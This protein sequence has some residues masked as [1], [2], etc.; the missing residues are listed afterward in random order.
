MQVPPE[1]IFKGVEETPRIDQA[2]SRGIARLERVCDYIIGVRIALEREQG[3]RQAGNPYRMRIDV[4][5]PDRSD[6]IVKRASKASKR[7]PASLENPDTRPAIQGEL[8]P[9]GSR[10]IGRVPTP[11]RKI[12]EEPLPALIRCTFDSA[13]RELEKVVD[14]QRG[15]VK[16]PAQQE[17][18]AV[19]EKIFRDQEYGFLR[20]LDGQQVYFHRNSV[21]HR[22]WERLTPGTIVRYT[23]EEG[24][25]GLQA[26]TVE[27]MNKPG[28]AEAHDQLHDLPEV[29]SGS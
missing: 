17:T 20:T 22:H 3:R 13:R 27:P 19:V 24:E 7:A 4:R 15:D 11:R 8:Q 26:S 2:I 5:V 1:I 12:P 28:V 21:L 6:I 16:T 18:Q 10:P 14:K 23:L 9:E 25:K 29:S